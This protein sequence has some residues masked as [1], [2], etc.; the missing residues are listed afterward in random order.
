VDQQIV[1]VGR[2]DVEITRPAKV[3]FPA[4]GITKG[5][6]IDYYRRIAPWVL[7][8]LRDRPLAM[9]RYPDGIDEPSFF[10]KAVPSY[11][12]DRIKTVTVKKAGERSHTWSVTIKPRL[13]ILLTRRASLPTSGSAALT[14]GAIPIKWFSIWTLPAKTS[15]R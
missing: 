14:N 10:Q 3:L 1:W 4:D 7:P 13:S 11:F 9:E 2:Y 12:P 15:K 8:H 6:L 5:D